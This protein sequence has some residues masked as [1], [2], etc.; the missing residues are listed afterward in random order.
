MIIMRASL[1]K[2]V[3]TS[4]VRRATDLKYEGTI[5]TDLISLKKDD[6]TPEEILNDY[7]KLA[8]HFQHPVFS[9]WIPT[10]DEN[11]DNPYGAWLKRY[12]PNNK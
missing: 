10:Y 2:I 6:P 9:S 8:N 3:H 7:R 5:P 11:I 12:I 1:F 4:V